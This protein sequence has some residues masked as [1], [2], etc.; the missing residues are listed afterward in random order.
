MD[1]PNLFFTGVV[2]NVAD[3][4]GVSDVAIA[5]LF[6]GSGTRLKILEY[7][8]C[9]LPVVSTTVGAEGLDVTDGVHILIADDVDLFAS[10]VVDL[11]KDDALSKKLGRAARDLVVDKYDWMK[12]ARKLA[13]VYLGFLAKNRRVQMK[14]PMVS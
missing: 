11:L 10:R 14:M 8:S 12:V 7:F 13:I 4:L 9:R 6:H 5:P 3:L 1:S 2:D